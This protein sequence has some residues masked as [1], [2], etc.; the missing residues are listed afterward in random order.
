MDLAIVAKDVFVAE[1]FG[2]SVDE[3]AGRLNL[4][5]GLVGGW[6]CERCASIMARASA[7]WHIS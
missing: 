5:L 2:I 6:P 7:G 1:A 3:L 4:E